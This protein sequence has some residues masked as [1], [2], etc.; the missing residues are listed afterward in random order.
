MKFIE[1]KLEALDDYFSTKKESEKWFIIVGIAAVIAYIG[2]AYLL[3]YTETMYK[4]SEQK[5]KTIE[6]R[7]QD[8]TLYLNSISRN[9]DREYKVKQLSKEISD[10]KQRIVQYNDKIR[11][12]N[13][14]LER[15]SDML[16]N[17]KSWSTF[18][19]SI[20]DKAA[21][22]D[23]DIEYINNKTVDHN[24]SFGHVLEINIACKGDYKGLVKFM[25][26]LEQNTLVTD[27]YG[28][29]MSKENNGSALATDINISV[30]GIN[31]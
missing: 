28:S 15:L 3:P 2:Y 6:K 7:I 30:W 31:H 29:K 25:N 19:N 21:M 8:N 18:L 17:K 27:I 22:H 11:K 10:K 24:R 20:T 23:I 13:Q 16:F 1:D 5:R 12:I 4:K 9:G 26:E 14:S